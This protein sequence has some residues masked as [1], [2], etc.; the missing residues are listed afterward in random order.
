MS[1]TLDADLLDQH[2][3]LKDC[4]AASVYRQRGGIHSTAARLDMSPSH[5]SEVLSG[6]GERHRKFDVNELVALMELTGDLSPL[7]W[8]CAR[9]LSRDDGQRDNS[10]Q[11]LAKLAEDLPRLLAAAGIKGAKR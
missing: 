6:G 7:H 11:Q 5:L 2:R 1:L 3:T 10:L 4:I 9:F 8:L